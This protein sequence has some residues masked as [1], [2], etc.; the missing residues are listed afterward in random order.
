M[1]KEFATQENSAK[2]I[3]GSFINS[4]TVLPS[5]KETVLASLTPAGASYHTTLDF[6]LINLRSE[7][8]HGPTF[9]ML[10]H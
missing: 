8:N 9:C 4:G 6:P 1:T 10:R 3:T 5:K 2:I 7:Q